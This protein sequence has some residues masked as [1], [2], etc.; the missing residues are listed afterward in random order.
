[1][2]MC[3]SEDKNSDTA[4]NFDKRGTTFS[5]KS[6]SSASGIADVNLE[7]SFLSMGLTLISSKGILKWMIDLIII[8]VEFHLVSTGVMI[9]SYDTGKK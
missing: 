4:S 7:F 1:M 5:S 9:F 8:K 6:K 3:W 2:V